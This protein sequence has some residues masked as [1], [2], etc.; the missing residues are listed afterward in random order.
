MGTRG[1]RLALIGGFVR[2]A[3][4]TD[5]PLIDLRL[6]TNSEVTTANSTLLLFA[7][8]FFGAVLLIPSCFQQLLQQTALQSGLHMMPERLGALLTMPIAGILLDKRGRARWS[9][10]VLR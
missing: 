9:W 3:L 7:A 8:A 10:P 1:R 2:H 5:N 4:G 6:F